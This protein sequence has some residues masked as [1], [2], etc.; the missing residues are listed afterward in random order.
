MFLYFMKDIRGTV[1]GEGDGLC[2]LDKLGGM[3]WQDKK[4]TLG[5]IFLDIETNYSSAN[6]IQSYI[7]R[8][9]CPVRE[10]VSKAILGKPHVRILGVQPEFCRK[11]GGVENPCQMG[12]GNPS[13][14]MNHY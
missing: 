5:R 12:C 9:Y 1:G 11:D 6:L 10:Q 7:L 2:Y 3:P 14:N 13:V 4:G 8:Q